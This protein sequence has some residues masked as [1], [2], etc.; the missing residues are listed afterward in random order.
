MEDV[1]QQRLLLLDGQPAHQVGHV[2]FYPAPIVP[3]LNRCFVAEIAE[4]LDCSW[5]GQVGRSVQ[6]W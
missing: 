6:R 4:G 5:L 1:F 3:E 2:A